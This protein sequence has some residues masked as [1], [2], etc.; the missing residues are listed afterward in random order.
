MKK[1]VY[2]LASDVTDN[3]NRGCC[4]H[5]KVFESTLD[6]SDHDVIVWMPYIGR[7]DTKHAAKARP[8]PGGE[9]TP[10]LL[11]VMSQENVPLY[12]YTLPFKSLGSLR[13]VFIFQRKALFFQ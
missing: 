7:T 12:L 1:N 13:N 2:F 4:D 10:P 9:V 5:L 11:S 8:A 3:Q 6:H